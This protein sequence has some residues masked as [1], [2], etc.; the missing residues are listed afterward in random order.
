MISDRVHA[1]IKKLV[2]ALQRHADRAW[3]APL[4]GLLSALDNLVLIIPTDGILISS[5]M[6]IPKR[7]LLFSVSIA[8]GSTLGALGLAALVE[9]QGHAW[10]LQVYPG[11]DQTLAWTWTERVFDNY[12]LLIVFALALTPLSQQPAVILAGLAKVPLS[13]LA[14]VVFAGR[15]IKYLVMGYLGSHAPRLLKKL[16]GLGGEL[17]DAGVDIK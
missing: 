4:I 9:F 1:R 7:W 14:A 8:V 6:L 5:S 3:Y 10:V 15:L 16:W 11:L 12:G 13:E 17:K 2:S